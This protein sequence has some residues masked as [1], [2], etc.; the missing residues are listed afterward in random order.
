MLIITTENINNMEVLHMEMEKE[1]INEHGAAEF[2]KLKV[3]T[4][5]NM[6]CA[7][8]GPAYLKV[9]H[10]FVRY[11]LDDLRAWMMSHRVDPEAL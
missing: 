10:K 9:G 6:R 4:L 11:R 2:L 1:F 5:R 8:R 7:N 3:G